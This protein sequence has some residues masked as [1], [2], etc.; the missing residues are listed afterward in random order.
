M[1][2]VETTIVVVE[3]DEK[4]DYVPMIKEIIRTSMKMKVAR[5]IKD[6]KENV[7]YICGMK[8]YW[9]SI[10]RMPKYLTNLYRGSKR[11]GEKK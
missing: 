7:C 6:K 2:A 9:V 4:E 1:E 3:E 5:M 10:F 8:R 11:K